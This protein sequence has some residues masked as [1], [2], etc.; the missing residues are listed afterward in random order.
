LGGYPVERSSSHDLVNYVANIINSHD[1]F[2]LAIT[3]E[4][5][6]KKVK[7]FKTGFYYIAKNAHVPIVPCGFDYR[8]KQIVIGRPLFPSGNI[9]ADF[10]ILYTFYGNIT[11]KNPELGVRIPAHTP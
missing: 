1:D 10:E 9:D 8:K 3:P 6:R 7:K 11:G 2:I 5:T 4:G